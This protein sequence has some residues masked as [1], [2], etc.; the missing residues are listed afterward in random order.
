M[1]QRYVD[2]GICADIP[3]LVKLGEE[4]NQVTSGFLKK[5][6][7]N[8]AG[9]HLSRFR[10]R[11]MDFAE[12]REYQ[13]GDDMRHIDWRVTARTGE[14][15]TKLFMEERERPVFVMLDMSDSMFFGS[16][17][18]FKS[19]TAARAAS[20]IT[21]CVVAAGDRIGAMI[22]GPNGVTDLRPRAGRRGALGL[23]SKLSEATILPETT[24]WRESGSKLNLVLEHGS[25]LI[26]PGSLVFLFSDF[27]RIDD[28]SRRFATSLLRHNDLVVCHVVDP[29]E[30]S[31]PKPGSYRFSDGYQS[32]QVN[33]SSDRGRSTYTRLFREREREIEKFCSTL[34]VSAVRLTASD[35]PAAIF[36]NMAGT[37]KRS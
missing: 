30:I 24:E 13:P 31:P 29:L 28:E 21:W 16:S 1:E 7:S 25:K 20:Y 32:R 14:T 26:H 37:S 22:A 2:A 35:S 15:H 10:G 8:L 9:P 34:A 4:I 12:S 6:R 11:G 17:A 18:G 23:I 3:S 36:G 27:Y 19:V 33:L 5:A